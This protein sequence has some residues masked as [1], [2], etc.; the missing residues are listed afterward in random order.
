VAREPSFNRLL[1]RASHIVGLS[2]AADVLV[3]TCREARA[4]TGAP[5]ALGVYALPRQRWDRGHHVVVGAKVRP[6]LGPA[7]SA[8][9]AVHRRLSAAGGPLL[10]ER[11]EDTHVLLDGLARAEPGWQGKVACAHALPLMHR[12]GRVVGEIILVAPDLETCQEGVEELP[13]L[14][15]LAA[16]V[17]ANTERLAMARRDQDRLL[18]LAETT[19]EAL[20]DLSLDTGELWWGGG[21]QKLLR[22]GEEPVHTNLDWKLARIHPDDAE[23]VREAFRQAELSTF[24][25]WTERY[26]FRRSDGSY[27]FVE[28]RGHFLRE[29]NGR[30]YRA[31]G[32]LRDVTDLHE[33]NEALRRALEDSNVANR[34][35]DEFLAMLGHELRN[36]LA[37]MSVGV[38]LMRLRGGS[39][40]ELEI[41][42][43]QIGHLTRLVDD[44]LDVSRITRGKV[45]LRQDAVDLA[46]VIGRAIETSSPL[47]EQRRHPLRVT[48]P[49]GLVVVGDEA[50]LAQAVS[51]LLTNA[52]KY[53]E[54]GAAIDI[55][56]S[57]DGGVA[58][59]AVRDRGLGIAPDML[60][61]IFDLFVQQ[62]QTIE[63]SQ[64]GLGLGLAIVKNLIEMH[65]GSVCA[66]SAGV[67]KGSEFT[68]EL[69]LRDA[70]AAEDADASGSAP[71]GPSSQ[72]GKRILVVDD[73]A[74][75]AA[76]LK[77][78]LE[79][80]GHRVEVAHDGFAALDAAA[81]FEPQIGLLDIG[82]PGMDGYEL[83]VQ[84]GHRATNGG[85]RLIA[86]TGYGQD[87]DRRRSAAA[88]FEHHFVKPIDLD[89]LRGLLEQP[90]ARAAP[91]SPS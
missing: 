74:D 21:I 7:L 37:P 23:R 1:E 57:S 8:A 14:A 67:G 11:G 33:S 69:P 55:R 18:L 3:E 72:R 29:P 86:V 53:S 50:R 2:Q 84:L 71:I 59:V 34:A 31:I 4:M 48:A 12:T 26:R 42:E 56:A 62:H 60:E 87:E 27:A 66:A 35:K 90:R 54:P 65:G 68:I 83:A 41:F 81:R 79:L 49:R 73:N 80:L 89:A 13:Q 63:R 28:D 43:R 16:A 25:A 52:A 78:A 44:L 88:G 30:P 46:E 64:G 45:A 85:I 36:P 20:W 61:R 51:N 70:R 77:A 19:D 22:G 9:F 6:L 38:Q 32:A 58:R 39:S 91:A 75:A 17:I 5:F 82:L 15:A 10:L 76:M 24:P 47:L 40:R